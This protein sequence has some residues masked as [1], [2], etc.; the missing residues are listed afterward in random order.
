MDTSTSLAAGLTRT[1]L[2]G[3]I[4]VLLSRLQGEQHYSDLL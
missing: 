1:P 4:V 3:W 2:R